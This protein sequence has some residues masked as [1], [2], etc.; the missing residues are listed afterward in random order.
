MEL[1]VC[2]GSAAA[3]QVT[4]DGVSDQ[5]GGCGGGYHYITTTCKQRGEVRANERQLSLL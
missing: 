2:L 5:T 3:D 4:L 1:Y